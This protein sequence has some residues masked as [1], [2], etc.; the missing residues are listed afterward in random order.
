MKIALPYPPSVW[1][2]Y[3]GHGAGRR[4][5][6]AY[7]KWRQQCGAYIMAA[8]VKS[9]DQITTPFEC[10]IKLKRQ[11]KRQDLDNRCKAVVDALQFYKIIS[12]D[13]LLDKLTMHWDADLSDEC[14]VELR[15][16]Q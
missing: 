4:L 3:V 2:L 16:I 6:P 15:A 12:N 13:N 7:T 11:N 1:N 8:G 9:K 5:S 14:V 10:T